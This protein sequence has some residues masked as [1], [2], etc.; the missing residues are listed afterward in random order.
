MELAMANVGESIV[1]EDCRGEEDIKRHLYDLGFVKGETVKVVGENAS[2]MILMIKGVK[3]AL[4]RGLAS[5]IVVSN[6]CESKNCE[7]YDYKRRD[8]NDVKRFETGR[9]RQSGFHFRKRSYET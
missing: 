1:I 5:K 7:E 4:N 6:I 9:A 3:L 2:G 8:E